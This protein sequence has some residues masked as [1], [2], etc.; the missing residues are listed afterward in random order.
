MKISGLLSAA[1]S[2]DRSEREQE[3]SKLEEALE[4]VSV[5]LCCIGGCCIFSGTTRTFAVIL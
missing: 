1:L 2:H 5:S 4:V 3:D